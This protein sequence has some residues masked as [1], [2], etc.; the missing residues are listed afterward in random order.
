M[1]SRYTLTPL[2]ERLVT[3]LP[4]VL[5]LGVV[6]ATFWLASKYVEPAPPKSFVM[7]TASKGSPYWRA[8]ERYQLFMAR[9]G[10]NLVLQ[11]TTGSIENMGLLRS[12]GSGVQAAILQGGITSGSDVTD[13]QS[14]GRIAYEPVWIFYR[15][16]D[17]SRL[18]DLKGR[19]ILVGPAGGGTNFLA[20]RLLAASG[21]TAETATLVAMEL[22]DYVDELASGKADAGLLVL[23]PE[24]RTIQRL[25]ALPD[26]KLM[27]LSQADAF[28]QRFPYL[29]RIE[30]KQGVVDFSRNL[31]VVDTAMVATLAALVVRSDLHPALANLLA[32]AVV[33]AHAEP[34]VG[35]N[36]EAP[37]F[38]RLAEFP[39]TNDPEFP[40]SEDARRVYKSGAPFLQRFLPFWLA[41]LLDR[42]TVMLLPIIGVLLPALK[43]GPMAYQ[44]QVRRRLLHW[45][46]ELKRLERGLT[47][48][49]PAHV[50]AEKQALVEDIEAAVNEI[51]IPVMFAN[52]HFDLRQHIDVVRRR[53]A[54]LAA[55]QA[56]SPIPAA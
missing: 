53:L 48:A 44:W 38:Q 33:S 22:P 37:I 34:V 43:L 6:A 36:G 14:I 9:N 25:F 54:A 7:A 2:R 15:G 55:Q 5:V 23:G 19:R 29:S 35:P 47:P 12:A 42:M 13:L 32:Q 18:S 28:S 24:A 40:L 46:R 11:E 3:V 4:F 10:V 20:T 49:T 51:P 50:I 52:Q 39:I 56:A 30:L 26:V 31:P 17:I 41:T 1:S 27:S 21:V 16:A 45:Y 8:A